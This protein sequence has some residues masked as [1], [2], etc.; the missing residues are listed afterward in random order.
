MA[1][2]IAIVVHGRFH[3]FDL[4]REFLRLGHDVTLFTNYPAF[5]AR[6]FGIPAER[7]R[8]FL[9][10]GV[11]TRTLWCMFPRGL[12]GN[13]EHLSNAIFGR[14]AAGQVM[15]KDWDVVIGFS[16]VSEEIFQALGKTQTLRVLQRG[17]AHIRVQQQILLEE[18]RRA[19]CGLDKPSDWIVVREER[20]YAHA[21]IIH[22]L[23][24][25]A[26][27]SFTAQGIDPKKLFILR[28]GVSTAAFRAPKEVINTR[29]QRI[30]D[31]EPLR[32]LNVGTFSYRKGAADFAETMTYLPPSRF[33][34]RFVGPI[35][36]E[37]RGLYK[38]LKGKADFKRKRPQHKLPREYEWGDVFALPTIEDGFAVVL[39]QALAAGLPL[40]TTTNCAG[41]DLICEGRNGWIIP[42]RTGKA[43]IERLLWLD[44]NRAEL[45]K[46]IQRV[47]EAQWSYDWCETA[48]QAEQ[49]ILTGL[50]RKDVRTGCG[51]P[52]SHSL[53]RGR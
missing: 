10:H 24:N 40:L 9:A 42:I 30:L 49:N 22:V 25:F 3:A 32:V 51:R 31:G 6:R 47:Y 2:K 45:V 5:V 48:R 39:C 21:D 18:E 37:V 38:Q 33:S 7:V 35:A 17:S 4:A 34:F 13:L 53:A 52:L 41:P 14:W 16:G 15:R 36:Y 1:L 44:A 50:S 11:S 20:E 29:C 23:S 27:L 12:D 46:A 26:H 43:F 28:L 19:G 8:S